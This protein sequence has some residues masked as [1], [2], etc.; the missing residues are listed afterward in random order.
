LHRAV[1]RH[2]ISN[3]N[4]T[5]E[6]E[7]PKIYNR[8][9]CGGQVWFPKFRDDWVVDPFSGLRLCAKRQA[10][11]LR[12]VRDTAA[13][14]RFSPLPPIEQNS[15][16]IFTAHPGRGLVSIVECTSQNGSQR[17]GRNTYSVK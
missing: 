3:T 8:N 11:R 1:F 14:R 6:R 2:S 9:H 5:T 10:Q 17:L 16:P 13:L 4:K 15:Q 12:L 7:W